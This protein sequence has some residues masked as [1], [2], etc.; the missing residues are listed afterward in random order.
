MYIFY[1]FAFTRIYSECERASQG[2]RFADNGTAKTSD[3]NGT[4]KAS[5]VSERTDEKL[6]CTIDLFHVSQE[7]PK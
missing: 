3:V 2:E 7:S 1:K 6:V 4:P 5:G